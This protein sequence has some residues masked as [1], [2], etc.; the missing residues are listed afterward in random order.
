MAPID[1]FNGISKDFLNST[2]GH[3]LTDKMRE[4]ALDVE[5]H[6]VNESGK[7]A[8]LTAGGLIKSTASRRETSWFIRLSS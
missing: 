6:W 1:I 5:F 4:Q 2:P 7:E 8:E 3:L